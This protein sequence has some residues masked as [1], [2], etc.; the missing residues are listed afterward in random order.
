MSVLTSRFSNFWS[1]IKQIG[2]IF[3]LV[4]ENLKKITY[5]VNA[6]NGHTTKGTFY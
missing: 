1:Q 3:T 4:G 5:R 2:G 6:D